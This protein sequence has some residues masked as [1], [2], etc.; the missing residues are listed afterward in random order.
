MSSRALCAPPHGFVQIS[1]D[2]GEFLPVPTE[3]GPVIQDQ[4]AAVLAEAKSQAIP[5]V[6]PVLL[7]SCDDQDACR[8]PTECCCHRH[9]R[10]PCAC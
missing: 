9:P 7:P 3:H 5:G 4:A 2:G 8:K 10:R 1:L 6:A